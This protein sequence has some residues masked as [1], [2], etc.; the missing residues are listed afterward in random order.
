MKKIGIVGGIAWQSTVEYYRSICQLSQARFAALGGTGP[1]D[2]PEFCIESVNIR[3]S[4]SRR[5]VAGD[6]ASWARFDAYFQA[7]LQRLQ[8]SGADFAVIAS[9]TPHNRYEAITRGLQMPVLSLF[10][11]VAQACSREGVSRLLILGTEPTMSLPAFPA[12]LQRHGIQSQV[13]ND[14]ADRALVHRLIEDLQAGRDEGASAQ[15]HDLVRRNFA[16]EPGE[17]PVVALAC[18]ELPLAFPA[19]ADAGLFEVGGV[20]YV[21]TTALH[22]RAAFDCA[23]A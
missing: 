17:R 20:L 14:T 10:E 3:Q 1:A 11:V 23:A 15:L 21:N 4:Q 9:N 19:F 13:P 22:A 7:A 5:G 12:V 16:G 6:E 8:A 2:M 18:T